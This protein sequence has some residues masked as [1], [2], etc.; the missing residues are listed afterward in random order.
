MR[1]MARHHGI[2]VHPESGGPHGAPIDSL[3]LMGLC[4]IPMSEFW[5]RATTHRTRD[6]DRFFVKQ[7]ASAAHTYGK[8]LVAAEGFTVLGPHWE[9]TLWDNLKPSFDQAACEGLNRLVWCSVCCSPAEMGIPGQEF[10]AGAHFNPNV[11][12]WRQSAPFLKYLNRCQHLLQ[13]GL[14]VADACHYYGDT[15]PNFAQLKASDP[16]HV[17]PGYDYDVAT[18]EVLLTRMTVKDGRIVLPDGMSYRVLVLPDRKLMPVAV[19]RKLKELVEAGA[20]VVGPRPEHDSGLRDYPECDEQVRLAASELW[21]DVNGQSVHERRVGKGRIVWGKTAREVLFRDAVAP[22]FEFAA[23]HYNISLDYIHRRDRDAEIYFV[24][25]RLGREESLDCLFR[26]RGKQP[27]LWDPISGEIRPAKA[28]TQHGGRTKIPLDFAPYGSLFVVFRKPIPVTHDG[29]AAR[30]FPVFTKR[31]QL[32]GPWQVRFDPKWGGPASVT[33][34]TLIDWTARPESGIQ[35]YSGTATYLK[36]FDT[37]ESLDGSSHKTVYLDLGSVKELAAVR[38]NGRDLGVLWSKPFRVD[39]S[40]LLKPSGNT[41]E[42]EVTNFWPNR[43]IGDASLDASKRFTKT[44]I[45]KF[46]PDS[47]LRSSGLLGPVT[48]AETASPSAKILTGA[49]YFAGWWR[50]TPNKWQDA[51]GEDWRKRYPERV[52]ILGEYNEQATMDQEILAASRAGLNYF[53]MLWYPVDPTQEPEPGAR[54][55]NEGLAC[56]L[57]SSTKPIG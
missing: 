29:T 13:A 28:F 19:T 37:P 49:S 34:P 22:D 43:L 27:E 9:E 40:G 17:L 4:D 7:P 30:N 8:R 46:K 15:V 35:H 42:V 52:P 55:L 5:A 31:S 10:F 54:F 21:G 51:R 2:G 26:V 16:A 44:N 3:R 20:T 36:T 12:W 41:L 18:E 14:F 57:K 50:P 24:C 25:N 33:F 56:F 11:T 1:E 38:L 53:A 6:V 32:S 45:R 39:I 48:L 47:P 23:D